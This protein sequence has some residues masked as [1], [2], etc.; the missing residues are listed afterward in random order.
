MA[1][2]SR[3]SRDSRNPKNASAVVLEVQCEYIQ[4]V[5]MRYLESSLVGCM[6]IVLVV[7]DGT[8]GLKCAA[9]AAEGDG[10]HIGP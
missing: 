6:Q 1:R 3:N 7:N 8:R 9:V 4:L 2:D 10:Y 5:K